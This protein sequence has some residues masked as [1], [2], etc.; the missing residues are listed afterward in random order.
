MW[1]DRIRG[2]SSWRNCSCRNRLWSKRKISKVSRGKIRGGNRVYLNRISRALRGFWRVIG[3]R[4]IR[5][6]LR[7]VRIC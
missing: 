4:K 6:G 1:R 2:K 3:E 7:V 5:V